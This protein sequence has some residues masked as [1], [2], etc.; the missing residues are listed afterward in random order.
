MRR[1]LRITIFSVISV[2]LAIVGRKYLFDHNIINEVS[3]VLMA[4][5]YYC[6]WGKNKNKG[7]FNIFIEVFDIYIFIVAI[8]ILIFN[9]YSV[10]IVGA[11]TTEFVWLGI[12]CWIATIWNELNRNND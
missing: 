1:Y 2:I 7:V 3:T 12:A 5:L 4:I 8:H 9:L 11:D 6:F 10:F